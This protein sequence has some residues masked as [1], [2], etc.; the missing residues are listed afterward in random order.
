M[1]TIPQSPACTGVTREATAATH[2]RGP[3]RE[4]PQWPFSPLRKV[5]SEAALIVERALSSLLN[6]LDEIGTNS[7][8]VEA[9][10]H[11]R[12]EL[13]RADWEHDL[14][15]LLSGLDA[16]ERVFRELDAEE[17]RELRG[18]LL[19]LCEAILDGIG[20]LGAVGAGCDLEPEWSS[21]AVPT[22]DQL[23]SVL[24]ALGQSARGGQ[25]R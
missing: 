10:S 3:A 12:Q 14:D 9:L 2:T 4:R 18:Q 5:R 13:R 16:I 25:V 7:L 6:G 17:S 1:Q 22:S 8:S 21:A 24:P 15:L 11:F 19:E 20:Y 23:M